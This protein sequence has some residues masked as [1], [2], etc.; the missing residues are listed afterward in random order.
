M[1]RTKAINNK[2]CLPTS[3]LH[4]YFYLAFIRVVSKY[5]ICDKFSLDRKRK[6]KSRNVRVPTSSKNI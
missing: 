2:Y 3:S 5:Y 6:K 1:L 4:C